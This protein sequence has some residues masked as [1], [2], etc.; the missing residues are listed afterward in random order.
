MLKT[1]LTSHIFSTKQRFP[2]KET[3]LF[4]FLQGRYSMEDSLKK[5]QARKEISEKDM[6]DTLALAKDIGGEIQQRHLKPTLTTRCIRTAFQQGRDDTVRMSL[7]EE[8]HMIVEMGYQDNR[9]GR[10]LTPPYDASEVCW[11][12]YGILEVKLNLQADQ[13]PPE[14]ISQLINS[15]L[16]IP[17]PKFSKYIHGTVALMPQRVNILP[18]WLPL[19]ENPPK[20]PHWTRYMALSTKNLP[21][22]RDDSSSDESTHHRADKSPERTGGDKGKASKST[23]LER[24]STTASLTTSFSPNALQ[25]APPSNNNAAPSSKYSKFVGKEED[26]SKPIPSPRSSV[27]LENFT[28]LQTKLSS[29]SDKNNTD[30]KGSN[31]G[32]VPPNIPQM[33][34]MDDI[35]EEPKGFFPMLV[36]RIKNYF[37][38]GRQKA[39]Q[40]KSL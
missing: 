30:R 20:L 26:L 1:L 16:V 15:N 8:L 34:A 13:E 32:K 36:A 14:W 7:D 39:Y 35:E 18:P 38:Y 31:S 3:K 21:P 23:Q 40:S 17:V 37:G 11:F 5:K 19:L 22:E 33:I 28:E 12:P 4:E 25:P 10:K 27:K 2:I 6:S 24:F 29:G 9:W